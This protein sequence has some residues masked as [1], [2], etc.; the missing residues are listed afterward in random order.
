ML[1]KLYPFAITFGFGVSF[2]LLLAMVFSRQDELDRLAKLGAAN[3]ANGTAET[4]TETPPAR[5][6]LEPA[7][8]KDLPTLKARATTRELS[9]LARGV[10]EERMKRHGHDMQQ[11][12][13]SVITLDYVTAGPLANHIATEPM[14]SRPVEGGDELLNASLSREFFDVQEQLSTASAELARALV[15]NDAPTIARAMGSLTSACVACHAAHFVP[16]TQP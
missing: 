3:G 9:T 4:T 6:P 14:L 5:R 11:L 1:R 2:A 10:L 7:L 15:A 16:L 13:R 8:A 12:M